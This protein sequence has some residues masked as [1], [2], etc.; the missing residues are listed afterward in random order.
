MSKRGKSK[1]RRRR[2]HT[3]IAVP[4]RH[5]RRSRTRGVIQRRRRRGGGGNLSLKSLPQILQRNAMP[6]LLTTVGFLGARAVYGLIKEQQPDLHP[7][8]AVAG[9]ALGPGLAA[10]LAGLKSAVSLP[11]LIGG[12][13][14]AG[15]DLIREKAAEPF[16]EDH[17][18]IASA[19]FNGMILEQ[20]Q[21][22]GEEIIPA[23]GSA[24]V[25]A[26]LQSGGAVLAGDVPWSDLGDDYL[27]P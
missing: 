1:T 14:G 17:P 6:I 5:H 24:V 27:M 25:P 7:G 16:A 4:I 12:I 10:I 20:L 2:R 9:G 21:V 11:L 3:V 13:A 15:V 23:G 26:T 19:I 22:P 18:Q 8:V